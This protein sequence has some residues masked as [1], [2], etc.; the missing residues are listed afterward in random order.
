MNNLINLKSIQL[1]TI[2]MAGMLVLASSCSENRTADSKEIAEQENTANMAADD[3]TIVVIEN[4]S[5]TQFLMDVAE[6]QVEKISLGKLAQEKGSSAHV[7]ELGK[8]MEE[9]HTKSLTE[10]KALAQSKSVS[11]PTTVTE[12][13][14]DAY[15]NLENKTGNDFGKAYSDKMVEYHEDAIELFEKAS[16]ESEDP[17]IKAWA[18]QKLPSLRVHLG[19]AEACKEECDKL[20]S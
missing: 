15:E 6:M 7:K 12:N 17:E 10:I 14:K 16:N 20:K 8:M 2:C 5:D 11:I 19:H 18:S 13:S 3:K 1:H 9:D 4:D